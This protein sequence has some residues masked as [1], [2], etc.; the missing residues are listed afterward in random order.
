MFLALSMIPFFANAEPAVD[1]KEVNVSDCKVDAYSGDLLQNLIFKMTDCIVD[2]STD[3]L[4]TETEKNMNRQI[5]SNTEFIT[6][7]ED[8][9][10]EFYVMSFMFFI[11]MLLISNAKLKELSN[12][13]SDTIMRILISI[14]LST[15]L[16]TSSTAIWKFAG[17]FFQ[18]SSLV[19]TSSAIQ[20]ASQELDEKIN[21]VKSTGFEDISTA[22]IEIGRSIMNSELC[23]LEYVQEHQTATFDY[24]TTTL[25][26]YKSDDLM[27]CIETERKAASTS[28]FENGGRSPLNH[29]VKICSNK[30]ASIDYDCGKI[31]YTGNEANIISVIET[32]ATGYIATAHEFDQSY[33]S[34]QLSLKNND[35]DALFGMCREWGGEKFQL[36]NKPKENFVEAKTLLASQ[37]STLTTNLILNIAKSIEGSDALGREIRLFSFLEQIY[38][39]M[40]SNLQGESP[41]LKVQVVTDSIKYT[42]P[43]INNQ[44]KGNDVLVESGSYLKVENV[45][46][47]MNSIKFL[48]NQYLDDNLLKKNYYL[49]QYWESILDPK[50]IIGSYKTTSD[51][52]Q[53]FEIDSLAFKTVHQY[54]EDLFWN[55]FIVRG[56]AN[57]MLHTSKP[58]AKMT[59]AF[60]DKLAVFL[61][62]MLLIWICYL[63][64]SIV[65]KWFLSLY[66]GLTVKIFKLY[67][68]MMVLFI[69]RSSADMVIMALIDFFLTFS[70]AII[71][72]FTVTMM[73]FSLGLIYDIA[74]EGFVQF[75]GTESIA[76]TVVSS[77]TTMILI[78]FLFIYIFEVVMVTVEKAHNGLIA[79]SGLQQADLDGMDKVANSSLGQIKGNIVN[80]L[81]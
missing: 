35:E 58:V 62:S 4:L 38:G 1:N 29:A 23:S 57:A 15:V 40:A 28:I 64:F 12:D 13:P 66:V 7:T 55:A 80:N 21:K 20:I 71:F 33:C 81:R 6:E 77:I 65:G 75:L 78:L 34:V 14:F 44:A 69:T 5:E 27:N 54:S 61:I 30:Y 3:D 79:M 60:I 67:S 49:E 17:F 19:P 37:V 53:N 10:K 56:A 31:N 50:K 43:Y 18:A 76:L 32:A 68:T 51:G 22:S 26:I 47:Y 24:K 11:I 72:L 48:Y 73:S 39:L 41:A 52:Y 46:D 9:A 42:A 59:G 74:N 25:D 2:A 8:I 36:K 16:F 45:H 70:K 63:M